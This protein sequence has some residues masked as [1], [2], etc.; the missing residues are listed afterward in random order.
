MIYKTKTHS[1]YI[2]AVIDLYGRYCLAA[3]PMVFTNTAVKLVNVVQKLFKT[4]TPEIF[5]SDQGKEAT[6]FA[7]NHLLELNGVK[8]SLSRRGKPKDN[9]CNESFFSLMKIETNL[10]ELV[11]TKTEKQV[12]Q[13]VMR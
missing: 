4:E 2:L 7:F 1:I 11:K 12:I 3:V 13:I 6:S 5:H 10:R 8:Q 9:A